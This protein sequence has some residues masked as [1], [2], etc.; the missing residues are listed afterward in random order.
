MKQLWSA[1]TSVTDS[2]FMIQSVHKTSQGSFLFFWFFFFTQANSSS[3]LCVT[4]Y[5]LY[6]HQDPDAAAVQT[7][8]RSAEVYRLQIQVLSH[9]PLNTEQNI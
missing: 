7:Q 9:L 8:S 6:F 2:K 4:G 1:A 3:S 5:I